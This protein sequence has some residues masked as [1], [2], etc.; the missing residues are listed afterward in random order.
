VPVP[1]ATAARALTARRPAA[2]LA[3]AMLAALPFTFFLADPLAD[4]GAG[5]WRA[6]LLLGYAALVCALPALLG[7]GSWPGPAV[8]PLRHLCMVLFLVQLGL[9][10][11][12]IVWT[13]VHHELRLDQGQNT[14]RAVRLLLAGENP[15]GQ[16][17][18]LDLVTFD[19]RA[20]QRRDAG[21]PPAGGPRA[22][23]RYWHTLSAADRD[24]ILP[25]LAS[26]SAEAIREGALLG[27]KYGPLDLLAALP[28]VMV[29][30]PS[31]VPILNVLCFVAFIASVFLL[32][33][34]V[35]ASPGAR[36]LA[37]ALVLADPQ[38]SW[39]FLLNTAMDIRVLLPLALAQRA[40]VQRRPLPL[41]A[42]LGAA[43]A[44][45]LVPAVLYFP[46]LLAVNPPWTAIAVLAAV[47]AVALA[48]FFLWDATG[49]L[50]N[51]LLWGFERG[52]DATSWIHGSTP[53]L[54]T[55]GR[56]LLAVIT[57]LLATR[58][59]RPRTAAHCPF[60]GLFL[61]QV[62]VILGSG[63]F[64]ND[65]LPWLTYLAAASIAARAP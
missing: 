25:P 26:P 15:Y 40:F 19:R 48:P 47:S 52:T 59:A 49:A 9:G 55:G 33:R 53:A 12:G 18:I 31:G 63:M 10:L 22:V 36:W 39:N 13:A 11:R 16:R 32:L 23:E 64:H 43:A 8:R 5:F 58:L 50:H 35:G 6:A 38:V 34:D 37:L 20:S 51:L 24:R 27:Y 30:G 46:L 42:W 1:G 57:L 60:R 3:L 29:F 62:A 21:Y 4:R 14:Y 61:L 28:L 2:W 56:A 41:A 7:R 45:K 54:A 17:T 65:Y 44:V